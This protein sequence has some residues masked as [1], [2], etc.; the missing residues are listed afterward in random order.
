MGKDCWSICYS[1]CNHDE[2][3]LVQWLCYN[4]PLVDIE[5]HFLF[6]EEHPTFIS[7]SISLASSPVSTFQSER[8][9]PVRNGGPLHYMHSQHGMTTWFATGI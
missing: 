2:F 8:A 9:G 1:Q 4:L 6:T 3:S 7:P 5:L